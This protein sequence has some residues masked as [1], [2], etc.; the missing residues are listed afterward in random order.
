MFNVETVVNGTMEHLTED[1]ILVLFPESRH[2][3]KIDF[4][5]ETPEEETIESGEDCEDLIESLL[6]DTDPELLPPSSKKVEMP[7]T[8]HDNDTKDIAHALDVQLDS[9]GETLQRLRYYLHEIEQFL[10]EKNRRRQ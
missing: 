2:Y 7:M 9:L 8:L 5:E 6:K 4:M 1:K 10:P 3:E